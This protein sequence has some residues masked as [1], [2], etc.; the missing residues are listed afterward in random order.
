MIPVKWRK[1]FAL[2]TGV[3]LLWQFIV[4]LTTTES[5]DRLPNYIFTL[6]GT[7]LF[8]YALLGMKL[9]IDK[10]KDKEDDE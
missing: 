7:A 3:L 8:G 1:W 2:F 10:E 5:Q 4:L 9:G 6:L